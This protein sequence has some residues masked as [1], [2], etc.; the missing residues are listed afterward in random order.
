M[1]R[2]IIK[3]F[4]FSFF[5]LVTLFGIFLLENGTSDPFYQRFITDEK[6]SLII[7]TSRAAQGIQPKILNT[8]LGLEGK[9][10]IFNYS[11][12]LMHSPFGKIYQ[13]SIMKKLIKEDYN[14]GIFIVSIDP[15]TISSNKK[16]PN[17]E[18]LFSEKNRFLDNISEVNGEVNLHYLMEYYENPYYEIL[19]RRL[20]YSPTKLHEDGWLEISFKTKIN[21]YSRVL[22]E[23]KT[24]YLN[25]LNYNSFSEERFKAFLEIIQELDKKGKVYLVRLPVDPEILKIDNSLI[26]DFNELIE[27]VAK[28]KNCPYLD[29]TPLSDKF[30]YTDGNHLLSKSGTEVSKIIGNWIKPIS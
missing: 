11:F 26:P 4:I 30:E 28:E 12:T 1:K 3:I 13:K 7:G 17:D 2:F 8:I 20:V 21:H 10:Q 25:N 27:R 24:Q 18:D 16:N 22:K 19:L 5:P 15:W 9:N 14:N 23:K 29:L 6:K